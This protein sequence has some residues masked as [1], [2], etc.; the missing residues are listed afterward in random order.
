MMNLCEKPFE[1]IGRAKFDVDAPDAD[2]EASGN[3]EK[4]QP[5]LANR[6]TF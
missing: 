1:G 3:F 4:P 6:G 2:F 5:D